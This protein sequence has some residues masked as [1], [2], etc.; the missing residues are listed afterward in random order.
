MKIDPYLYGMSRGL[1]NSLSSS[2]TRAAKQATAWYETA[3]NQLNNV[4][5]AKCHLAAHRAE[6]HYLMAELD[7]VYG[8]DKNPARM[9]PQ[10]EGTNEYATIPAGPRKGE[11]ITMREWHFWEGFKK[12]FSKMKGKKNMLSTWIEMVTPAWCEIK[13][14]F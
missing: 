11:R 7:K 2:L 14:E 6:I 10:I 13:D 9:N 3:Q 5:M 8:K 1:N 4:N 12:H